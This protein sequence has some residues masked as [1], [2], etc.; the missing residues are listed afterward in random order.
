MA[1]PTEPTATEPVRLTV[2]RGDANLQELAAVLAVLS[3]AAGAGDGEGDRAA[4]HT[5]WASPARRLG[6]PVSPGPDGWRGS[7]R[8]R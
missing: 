4:R 3:A 6:M 1:D 7:A 8:P 5:E 2:V